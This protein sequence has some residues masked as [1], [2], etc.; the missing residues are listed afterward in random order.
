METKPGLVFSYPASLPYGL[1]VE[2]GEIMGVATSVEAAPIRPR[3]E[4]YTLNFNGFLNILADGGYTFTLVA[5]ETS[6]ITLD[7]KTYTTP[8]LFPNLCGLAGD[9]PRT[10]TLY[11]ALAKGLHTLKISSPHTTGVDSLR[12]LWQAPNQPVVDVPSSALVHA[13]TH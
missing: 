3:P 9:A 11:A 7:S 12:L 2:Q 5:N 10:V 6:T 1:S 13:Q 8:T 4:N